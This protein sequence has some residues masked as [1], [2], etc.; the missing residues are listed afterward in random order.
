MIRKLQKWAIAGVICMLGGTILPTSHAAAAITAANQ[1]HYD[2]ATVTEWKQWVKENAVFMK[3]N[4]EN[5]KSLKEKD[6]FQ[7]LQFLKPLLK[8]KRMVSL[9]EASHGASEYNSVKVRLVQFLHEEMG[10]DVIAFESLL[11]DASVA[12]AQIGKDKPKETM[13]KA[14]YG[15]WQVEEN[16][17]LFEYI[18][19]RSK[20]DR[21]LIL[22][23][24][25]VQATTE[26][27]KAFG[28]EWF[29]SVDPS[30]GRRFEQ[31][32]RRFIEVHSFDDMKKFRNVQKDLIQEYRAL[33]TFV[34]KNETKLKSLI[35]QHED[36][37]PIMKRVLQN[38]IDVLDNY[39]EH[40]V[41]MWA[42]MDTK[43]LPKASYLRDKM[44]AD[45]VAWLAEEMYPD[46]KIIL[47]GHNYHIRKH[48]STMITEHNGM[49]FSNDPYP[50]MGEM[51]PAEL[52]RQHYVIG[53]YAYQG[54]SL[55]NNDKTEAVKLPHPHGSLE[56]ILKA[57]GHPV[58]FINL[59]NQ[60][61]EQGTSW[62]YTPRVAKAWGVLDEVMIA[63]DQY[64]GIVFIDTIYPSKR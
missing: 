29:S 21:P 52:Q 62:M 37:V 16:L 49:G 60:P 45:N 17:A 5:S 50:T 27:F 22:T 12:Y 1:Q 8:D 14:I 58:S 10:F 18:V 34:A 64:D 35:P 23:G 47:W 32:E 4:P 24:F 53:L 42:D 11:G 44:M 51:L 55:K 9:G 38:R 59:E 33:Q 63:R 7:D 30:V 2:D 20:T 57:G 26:P 3:I 13:N 31:A 41:R 28:N 19:E 43:H 36:M 40:M 56:D 39:V 48:N 54:S 6:V 25:D 61:L 46:K 15:V